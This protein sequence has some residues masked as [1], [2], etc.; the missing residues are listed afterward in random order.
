MDL[1]DEDI[2]DVD[3]DD[4]ETLCEYRRCFC[5]NVNFLSQYG[6][7]NPQKP[8]EGEILFCDA[9]PGGRCAMMTCDCHDDEDDWYSNLCDYCGTEIEGKHMATRIPMYYGGFKG[10]YCSKRCLHLVFADN[11]YSCEH[12]LIEIISAYLEEY[13]IVPEREKRDESQNQNIL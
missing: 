1:L 3:V 4:E 10:C 8:R 13:P 9:S 7:L 11:T 12:V 6:P 2:Y 5:D